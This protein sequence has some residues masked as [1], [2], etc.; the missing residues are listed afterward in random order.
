VHSLG[1]V[2]TFYN[3]RMLYYL[4][5]LSITCSLYIASAYNRYNPT[6]LERKYQNFI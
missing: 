6:K 5:G 4:K 1:N 3:K 2:T